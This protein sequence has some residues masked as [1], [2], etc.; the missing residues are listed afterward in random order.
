MD[1]QPFEY[2]SY[3][4]C[5]VNRIY[6]ISLKK[7]SHVIMLCSEGHISIK[8]ILMPKPEATECIIDKRVKDI[9]FLSYTLCILAKGAEKAHLPLLCPVTNAVKPLNQ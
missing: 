7:I 5:A 6:L 9:Y 3:F 8:Q 2:V 4:K 1:S